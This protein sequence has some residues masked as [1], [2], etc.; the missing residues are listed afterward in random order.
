MLASYVWTSLYDT[1]LL[2]HKIEV[3]R[4]LG[5]VADL[6]VFSQ[7]L[8]IHWWLKDKIT[9]Q[10]LHGFLIFFRNDKLEFIQCAQLAYLIGGR[11]KAACCSLCCCAYCT[12]LSVCL[13]VCF[14]SRTGHSVCFTWRSFVPW[15]WWDP[16]GGLRECWR[17]W[18]VPSASQW[19]VSHYSW[20]QWVISLQVYQD[21]VRNMRVRFILRGLALPVVTSLLL[22]VTLPYVIAAG[23]IPMFGKPSFVGL[24][25]CLYVS[26]PPF[27]LIIY[28]II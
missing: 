26:A 11:F 4:V 17:R 1:T 12:N 18:V 2:W 5:V 9:F 13:S 23:L 15:L 16:T 6:S 8:W 3:K 14:V 24:F 19:L 20:T 21:G 7:F 10:Y 27:S 22:A 25:V 28:S